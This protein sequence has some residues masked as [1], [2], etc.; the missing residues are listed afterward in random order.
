MCL[1][2]VYP[3]DAHHEI[4]TESQ[5]HWVPGRHHFLAAP[6][7]HTVNEILLEDC[8]MWS[9]PGLPDANTAVFS[10][11]ETDVMDSRLKVGCYPVI[12][13]IISHHG[14]IIIIP[15]QILLMLRVCNEMIGIPDYSKAASLL[16]E[17]VVRVKHR[18]QILRLVL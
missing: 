6:T 15:D 2:T 10:S 8:V 13:H 11:G 3:H 4:G 17:D 1:L 18:V 5:G 9:S 16:C 7:P 14:Y 12:H